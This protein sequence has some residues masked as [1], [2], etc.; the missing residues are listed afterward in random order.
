MYK[1]F[2]NN[3]IDKN[4]IP[5]FLYIS[6]LHFENDKNKKYHEFIDHKNSDVIILAGDIA[7]GTKAIDFIKYLIDL[8]YI[9]IY[10]IGNHEY[11]GFDIETLNNEWYE[12][13]K[14]NESLYFLN[15]DSVV[16]GKT[17]FF[18]T[19]LWTSLGKKTKDSNIDFFVRE[20]IKN[21]GDLKGIKNSNFKNITDYHFESVDYLKKELPKTES[22]KVVVI[23]HHLPTY[24]SVHIKYRNERFK[25]SNF[26]FYSSLENLICENFI[27]FWIHG[28]THETFDYTIYDTRILCNP[29]GYKDFNLLNSKFSWSKCLINKY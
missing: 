20:H 25:Y 11:Y 12:T 3:L 10:I 2:K 16:I 4:V 8:G 14:N 6:D 17:E 15:N 29:R 13:A 5:S 28:H 24:E 26:L 1:K 21:C 27:N 7:S 23:S 22:E 19:T 18:G 9:V